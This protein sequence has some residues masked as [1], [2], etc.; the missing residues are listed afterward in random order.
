MQCRSAT[1]L[2]F[3]NGLKFYISPQNCKFPIKHHVQICSWAAWS[4]CLDNTI[5]KRK[6]VPCCLKRKLTAKLIKT[7]FN[8]CSSLFSLLPFWGT[9]NFTLSDCVAAS[10]KMAMKKV[11]LQLLPTPFDD[12]PFFATIFFKTNLQCSNDACGKQWTEIIVYG[13][14][15]LLA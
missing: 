5:Y 10:K 9:L 2:C 11:W 8:L 4:I 3:K 7:L 12:V 13:Q 6:K 14:N 1:N 15:V